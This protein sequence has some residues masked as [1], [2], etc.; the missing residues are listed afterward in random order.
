MVKVRP[1]FIETVKE[2][3]D[4]FTL[5]PSVKKNTEVSNYFLQEYFDKFW[6][7]LRKVLKLLAKKL[8]EQVSCDTHVAGVG[9]S[10][11][12]TLGD[13][14]EE[15]SEGDERAQR[16]QQQKE[17][18][19]LLQALLAGQLQEHAEEADAK[20]TSATA[21]E[22]ASETE[23]QQQQTTAT[24]MTEPKIPRFW[25]EAPAAWVAQAEVILQASGT[26][27]DS[28]KYIAL[29]S[30]LTGPAVSELSD[31]IANPPTTNRF[32]AIKDAILSRFQDSADAQLRKLFG[33]LQLADLKPSQLLRQM[34]GLAA[35]KVSDEI[36][37]VRWLDLLPPQVNSI[38]RIMK[39]ATLDELSD[40]ADELA[41]SLPGVN[42]V[43]T[44]PAPA[45]APVH[46]AGPSL[47]Q[48]VAEIRKLLNQL[49]SEK[50]QQPAR[51]RSRSRSRGRN[52]QQ[53][54]PVA[55]PDWCWFHQRFG[56]DARN[57]RAPC[58]FDR[59][60]QPQPLTLT[61]AN[62]TPIPTFDN[63]IL[64]IELGLRRAA[65]WNFIVADT[66]VAIIGADFLA[67][68]GYFVDVKGKRLIDPTTNLSTP[69]SLAPA[70]I[71]SVS[72]VTAP[73]RTPP[74]GLGRRYADLFAEYADI[75]SPEATMAA[76]PDLPVQHTIHTTGPPVFERPR[77]LLGVR[78][79]AAK[80]EIGRLLN[81]G[82]VRPSSSQWA[83]PLHLVEKEASGKVFSVIDLRKAFYQIPI[84]E[85]DIPK[86]AMT[87]P[88]GVYELTRSSMGQRNAAQSL[89]RTMDHVLR[90]LPFARCYLDDIF[91]ASENHE[92]HL[93]HLRQLFDVLRKAKLRINP[94]KCFL[95]Q[96][97]VDYLG[98]TVS[99]DGVH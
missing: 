18:A 38:L 16:R 53:A 65:T 51:N 15:L 61:A 28:Q 57:C 80:E 70:A 23:Q 84:T 56:A 97:Q 48:E 79:K 13:S 82:I 96:D 92:Q 26:T 72:V 34:K 9:T 54:D 50:Q 86:T 4:T 22:A 60:L 19:E 35:G 89:Q 29:V 85:E 32:K 6:L 87:T 46:H 24:T 20:A 31:I 40:M 76:L 11:F 59:K 68:F 98:Y 71:H 75:C 62:A 3:L 8:F 64:T 44:P 91:V 66:Q 14:D 77:R 2:V 5:E 95:G 88:F 99:A 73:A 43:S 94:Q 69:G 58:S 41:G 42:A 74:G 33:Q 52:N 55:H 37:K 10:A 83:S 21:Q 27:D 1:Q 63:H 17:Q 12:A 78:L 30:A 67:H 47:A 93:Q 39:A 25:A 81:L 7:S 49:L 90:G 36:L 45:T